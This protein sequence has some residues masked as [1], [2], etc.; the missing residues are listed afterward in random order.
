ML[1]RQCGIAIAPL[2]GDIRG[3]EDEKLV[4][5]ALLTAYF[6]PT[7]LAVQRQSLNAGAVFAINLLLGWTLLGWIA[8][9]F[10]ALSGDTWFEERRRDQV[11]QNFVKATAKL[12]AMDVSRLTPEERYDREL[13]L[14]A[15]AIYRPD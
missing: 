2:R 10:M 12:M 4:L 11:R 7:L 5:T 14:A 15:L 9:L 6:L 3:A 13:K 8:A 1:T